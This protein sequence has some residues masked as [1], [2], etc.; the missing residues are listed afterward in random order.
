M[1]ALIWRRLPGPLWMKLACAVVLVSLLVV[2]L[3][4][5]VFP[6]VEPY[7]PFSGSGTIGGS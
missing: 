1:Y 5:W 7:L 6:W 2:L 4:G 3:F